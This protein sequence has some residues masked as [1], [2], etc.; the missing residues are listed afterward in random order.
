MLKLFDFYEKKLASL[1]QDEEKRLRLQYLAT[2]IILGVVALFMSVVNLFTGKALLLGA[3]LAFAL[4][5]ALNV[6]LALRSERALKI[7]TVI[8]RVEAI[9][10]FS[11]F[12]ISGTPEGFSAIWAAMLPTCGLLLFRRKHGSILSGIMFLIIIFLFWTPA[13]TSLLQYEYT[14]S[15]MLRF[16]M[17]YAAFFAMAFFLESVRQAT[18]DN[19]IYL[20]THDPLT[21]ALNRKGFTEYV[22]EVLRDRK[23]QPVGFM[24]ADLDHFKQVNDTYGHFTGDIVL[25]ETV[26][27]IQEAA[28]VPVCRWGGE[29]FA[30]I[31]P[32]GMTEEIGEKIRRAF[33]DRPILAGD[34]KILQTISVG[35]ANLSSAKLFTGDQ[36]CQ[37]SD[38]CLYEAKSSGRNC[39]MIRDL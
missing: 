7:S 23:E 15:F 6:Y 1:A 11:F 36:L 5:C 3:T 8:F 31:F 32:G 14:Q 16:P 25:K 28:G 24:I 4:L 33:S 18:F 29:E 9:A 35:G 2:Y 39:V 19:Y 17:L 37:E 20:Y 12:L 34:K 10:L 38:K 30:A 26:K 21:G 22:E 27:R 13:G